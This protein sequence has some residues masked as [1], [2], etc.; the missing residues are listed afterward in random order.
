MKTLL[1][2]DMLGARKKWQ[3]GG[4]L[5]AIKAFNHFHRMINASIRNDSPNS[6]IGGGIE[7]DSAMIIC[8]STITSLRIAQRLYRW[9]FENPENP[10]ANRLW[11]RGCIVPFDDNYILRKTS[12][13]TSP[14]EIISSHT[15][16]KSAFDAISI[17]KSGFK[18]MRLLV[19]EEI[20]DK[21][22]KDACKISFG[23]ATFI[24]IKRL[25]HSGYPSIID[26]ELL[27][28]LWMAEEEDEIWNDISLH[29]TSRLRHS[30]HDP[31]EFAQAAATQVVFH[32]CSAI[33]QSSISRMKRLESLL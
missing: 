24:T 28:F 17:E 32:E 1:F 19:R 15:Y 27:D 25:R 33:R 14:F 30:N 2:I 3:K 31:E 9:A 11:L 7:T 29:M 10:K 6:I 5:E 21:E 13:M 4:A 8:D 22:V 20:I 16:S 12:A 26:G 18:G 23:K